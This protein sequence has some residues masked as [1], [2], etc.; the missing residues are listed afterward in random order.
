LKNTSKR[1]FICLAKEILIQTSVNDISSVCFAN[2]L[3]VRCLSK[4]FTSQFF[5]ENPSMSK[6][7][8]FLDNYV[9]P[10]YEIIKE[11]LLAEL[12]QY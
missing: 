1:A 6:P 5:T 8:K 12:T 2:V 9:N 10:N 4:M 11:V 7:R 3:I